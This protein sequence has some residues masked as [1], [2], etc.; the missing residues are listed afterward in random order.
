MPSEGWL[1]G[2]WDPWTLGTGQHASSWAALA[3]G[4][5][6]RN[7]QCLVRSLPV[8]LKAVCTG[9][10]WGRPRL[11]VSRRDRLQWGGLVKL[12]PAEWGNT[13]HISSIPG[14]ISGKHP[15]LVFSLTA[16]E[17][18]CCVRR[19][20][21]AA[22]ESLMRWQP[23]FSIHTDSHLHPWEREHIWTSQATFCTT[24]YHFRF[25]IVS[26]PSLQPYEIG[27]DK[28]QGHFGPTC[29]HWIKPPSCL[30]GWSIH[31][32]DASIICRKDHIKFS[33]NYST[34]QPI[35]L[36]SQFKL[37]IDNLL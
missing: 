19:S 27:D 34:L 3:H 26:F 10:P 36:I 31:T 23:M 1:W 24:C 33:M 16:Q 7:S 2:W 32:S 25:K 28:A 5:S 14:N 30:T 9:T 35:F 20:P 21:G 15:L 8:Q 6:I 11:L 29:T 22:Q 4:C 37:Y 18:R 13:F 17:L 12:L